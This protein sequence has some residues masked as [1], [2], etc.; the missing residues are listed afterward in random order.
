MPPIARTPYAAEYRPDLPHKAR[1][2]QGASV[3]PSILTAA[4][5]LDFDDDPPAP[6]DP[7]DVPAPRPTV[8]RAGMRAVAAVIG[9]MAVAIVVLLVLFGP[10]G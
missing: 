5:W 7:G 1:A 2:R 4:A 8:L 9:G 6:P 10:P 3:K